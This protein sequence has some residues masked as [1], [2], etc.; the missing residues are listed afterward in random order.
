MREGG[1]VGEASRGPSQAWVRKKPRIGPSALAHALARA[2]RL[3][4]RTGHRYAH[5]EEEVVEAEEVCLAY[6]PMVRERRLRPMLW[7][8][9]ANFGQAHGSGSTKFRST[10]ANSDQTLLGIDQAWPGFGHTWPSIGR[11]V[12]DFGQSWLAR[13]WARV[14]AACVWACTSWH[15]RAGNACEM[16]SPRAHLGEP[17]PCRHGAPSHISLWHPHA[18]PAPS[19]IFSLVSENFFGLHVSTS[20]IFMESTPP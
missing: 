19:T 16:R 10:S 18:A 13:N 7:L 1:G 2:T 14:P 12:W 4:D 20:T 11:T 17:R 6:G 3:L 15:L 8:T 5:G 9:P